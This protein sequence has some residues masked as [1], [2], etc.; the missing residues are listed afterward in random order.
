MLGSI[1]A[2][3]GI[4]I[5]VRFMLFYIKGEGNGHT[6]SLI[7]SAILI[8]AGFQTIIAGLLGDIIA[9][10]RKILQDIQYRVRRNEYH[11]FNHKNK[12]VD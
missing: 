1:V 2:V 8:L 5:G 10:N 6:Q 12:E 9:A 7:L 3:L 4:A 11:R